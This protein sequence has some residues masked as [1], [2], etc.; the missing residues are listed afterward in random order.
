LVDV[1]DER[2]WSL[3]TNSRARLTTALPMIE[4]LFVKGRRIHRVEELLDLVD[5]D[6]DPMRGALFGL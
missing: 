4:I 1:H 5:E 3:R 2:E 6:L